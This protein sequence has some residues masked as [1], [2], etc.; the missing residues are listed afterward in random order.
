[1]LSLPSYRIVE[2][3]PPRGATARYRG[4]RQADGVAVAI[5]AAAAGSEDAARLAREYAMAAGLN[6]RGIVAPLAC[7]NHGGLVV[8]IR[9][10]C[11]GRPLADLIPADGMPLLSALRIAA[12]AARAVDELHRRQ[13]LHLAL[14]PDSVLVDLSGQAY[15]TDL[16]QAAS[17]PAAAR[18][19]PARPDNPAYMAPEQTGRTGIEIGP[20]A[21]LYAIGMLL[22]QLLTGELPF[23]V[24]DP[25]DWFHCHIARVP[26]APRSIRP[27]LPPA[28]D[29][30]V[31]KLLAKTPEER[32][33]SAAGLAWELLDCAGR[34][35]AGG[36]WQGF[37]LGAHDAAPALVIPAHLYGRDAER[38]VL[39]ETWRRAAAGRAELLLV[40][41]QAG[42]GKSA[43]VQELLPVVARSGG[44]F[45]AGKF[46][47]RNRATPYSSLIQALQELVRQLLAESDDRLAHGRDK[48]RSALGA[49]GQVI[50]DTLRQAELVLGPQQPLQKLPPAETRIRFQ[51]SL[52]DFICAF[53]EHDRPLAIFL[54]DLQWADAASLELLHHLLADHDTQHLLVVGAYR[55]TGVDAAHPLHLAVQQMAAAGV[56]CATVPLA[57]LNDSDVAALIADTLHS[58]DSAELER[59]VRTKTAGNPLF[60]RQFLLN[61]YAEGLLS[62]DHRSGRWAWDMARI[63]AAELGDDVAELM[64]QRLRRLSAPALRA[65]QIAACIGNRFAGALV[66]AVAA[67][68]GS[69]SDVAAALAEAAHEGLIAAPP[70]SDDAGMFRFS[71]DRIQQ[72]AY[73]MLGTAARTALHLAAGRA[74]LA[75]GE[76]PADAVFEIANQFQFCLDEITDAAERRR[77][78]AIY[79]QAGT[80]AKAAAAHAA[81]RDYLATAA[82]LA[83]DELWQGNRA[84]A[85]RLYTD[86]AECE[87][88]CGHA[89]VA[90]ALF[91]RVLERAREAGEI[92]RLYVLR[93]HLHMSQGRS[94]RA[95]E[96]GRQ[97]LQRLGVRLPRA[98]G[99]VALLAELARIAAGLRG[100]RIED[101]AAL[102]AM[103]DAR[104]QAVMHLYMNM[105]VAAYFVDRDLLALVAM[106]MVAASMRHGNTGSSAYAYVTF[107]MVIGGGF[108]RYRD[109]YRFGELG[110]QL[111]EAGGDVRHQGLSLA[112]CGIFTGAW[113]QPLAA[114]I[115]QLRRAGRDLLDCGNLMMTNYAAIATVFALDGKGE[116]LP[117]LAAEAQRQGEF[118]RKIG[119][120]DSAHYFLSTQRKVLCLQ[121]GTAAPGSLAGAGY[122]EAQHLAA[123]RAMT[124]RTALAWHFVN[125]LQVAYLC[126]QYETAKAA[127]DELDAMRAV[128][129]AQL[130][131]PR[132]LFYAA[133]AE[134]ALA[135]GARGA[136]RRRHLRAAA[137]YGRRLHALAASCAA[138]YRHLDLL[139]A[140]ESAA[141]NDGAAAAPRYDLA[142]KAAAE[143]GHTPDWALANERAAVHF[144][145]QGSEAAASQYLRNACHGYRQ[146][147]ATALALALERRHA[148]LIAPAAGADAVPE[149]TPIDMAAVIKAS[150][151]L[152]GEIEFGG[153]L[154]RLMEALATHAG[155]ARVV[156]ILKR[157]A[158]LQIED[159]WRAGENAPQCAGP[160]PLERC[161]DIAHAVVQYAA[162]TQSDVVIDDASRDNAFGADAYLANGGQKSLLCLPIVRHGSLL[163]L[164]YME[165]P[166]LRGAFHHERLRVLQ[167]LAAQL[168]ISIENTGLYERLTRAS[169]NLE[170]ANRGL[171]ERVAARTRELSDEIAERKRIEAA[172][173]EASTA[174]EGAN[175]AK[176]AFLANISHEIRTP[177]N[178]II[179]LAQLALRTELT[180]KQ[181]GYLKKLDGAAE[182]LLGLINDTLD[183][184]KIE[185]GKMSLEAIPFSIDEVMTRVADTMEIAAQ[186]KGLELVVHRSREIPSM[187]V[188]DPL[189][190]GQV[191]L[192]LASNAVKFTAGGEVTLAVERE[193]FDE[194]AGEI[195]LR[196]SVTDT[197]IG[198]SGEQLAKLFQPFSQADMSVTRTH[199]GTGLG[200]TIVKQLVQ[201]MGGSVEVASAPGVGS[202]FSFAARFGVAPAQAHAAS[203]AAPDYAGL[204][205]LV[206]DD[207]DS[208]RMALQHVLEAAGCR[209]T[210]VSG[211]AEAIAALRAAANAAPYQLVMMD[212]NMPGMDGIET[213]R[214]IKGDASIPQQPVVVMVTAYSRDE[215]AARAGRLATPVDAYLLKPVKPPLLF[216]TIS[217]IFGPAANAPA[218]AAAAP[219]AAAAAPPPLAGH[220]I[221]VV[222]DNAYNQLVARELLEGAG[223]AVDIAE[224]GREA[225]EAVLHAAAPYDAV[226]MDVQMP[227]MD[228]WAATRVLRQY[229]QGR[230]LPII[231]M[232]AYTMTEDLD[233]CRE[234]GMDDVITKPVRLD[235]LL[236]I[237]AARL[238]PAAPQPPAAAAL[239]PAAPAASL[240][241]V[242]GALGRLGENRELLHR[243]LGEF[244]DH[245]GDAAHRLRRL[246]A[247]GRLEEADRLVHSIKGTAMILGLEHFIAVAA[248]M[249]RALRQRRAESYATLLAPF[250]DAL[251]EAIGACARLLAAQPP[252]AAAARRSASAPPHDAL[253]PLLDE[254]AAL[255][256]RNNMAALKLMPQLHELLHG[257]GEGEVVAA[258]GACLHRLDFTGA[259]HHA[260]ALAERWPR[261]S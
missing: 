12:T 6:V 206:V 164:I 15:L 156:F 38:R 56:P 237:L 65:L 62:Y 5:L 228:G 77:L 226:L 94:D 183:M 46:E 214:R 242:A 108:A 121:G 41:G 73:A 201:L 227:V 181:Y 247:A 84:L 235:K 117:A 151:A 51:R 63:D 193:R 177:M 2:Q 115:V 233:R 230:A 141:A 150:Q 91:V 218:V 142:V 173:R 245:E 119:F 129:I 209:V 57:A 190:L 92:A 135:G 14:T 26:A 110:R 58:P 185:A 198:I 250:A 256:D 37:R 95:V 45:V 48:L 93:M 191:L 86:R 109:G 241:D 253:P 161:A 175:R 22:F 165:N 127:A 106:R 224:N 215:V 130:Y 61:L 70:G 111:G 249:E 7:E 178:A 179:G 82:A 180:P 39:F 229:P 89:D 176:S 157:D 159:E 147:G 118:V 125:R 144:L 154:R 261:Q 83:G 96:A 71:H 220:R 213:T 25:L 18:A 20:G 195:V 186:E 97:G 138:N 102:P 4:L 78:A 113:G 194:A 251:A 133:L 66:A 219:A 3:L 131:V 222:E 152:S 232:T 236:A 207:N 11:G 202:D 1:M 80:R 126:G 158:G 104:Q 112:M 29:Q 248:E 153:L 74:L 72:A 19:R 101:L 210:G 79:V 33:R 184:A 30:L 169:Q 197:G 34:I 43:L 259:R 155:A 221:L 231:G 53:A 28:L 166:L 36:D 199:G 136:A 47:E 52:H 76:P 69:D 120:H 35:E 140:A 174:A 124:E 243:L 10:E 188:G 42:L 137:R 208:A 24:K 170:E 100:R 114:S 260:R 255:L 187:L 134:V 254:F 160:M 145:R 246:I 123:M 149:A 168:A 205:V 27:M 234:A 64:T 68:T 105:T 139:V 17:L 192:N 258:I 55:D 223:L 44:H 54:D 116:A 143:S 146:W 90:E 163:G 8:L 40:A 148:D 244:R 216:D 240:I 200:L 67:G 238:P 50:V 60:V 16:G 211:G 107:G 59:L 217:G 21:D 32:Y 81:A 171:E 257:S 182:L 203:G 122:D 252:A 196:F 204:R 87:F 103:S 99:K 31:L 225:V 85:M 49:N 132:Q 13:R 23:R 9:A 212:W 189:R 75:G 239:P 128:S 88:L 172:L 167:L 162:R 98:P